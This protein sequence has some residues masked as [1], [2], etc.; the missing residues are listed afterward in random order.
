MSKRSRSRGRAAADRGDE[1]DRPKIDAGWC[2][3]ISE[4]SGLRQIGEGT[5]GTVYRALDKSMDRVVALKKV[6]LHN[7][8]QDGFPLTSLREIRLL[9]RISHPNCV[10][11]LDVAVGSEREAVYLVFEYCEHDLARLIDSRGTRLSVFSEAQ[12]KNLALQLLSA[13]AH[14]HLHWIVHRDLKMSNLLYNS[15]GHLKLADFGL[16]RE[17]YRPTRDM[18]LKV[19][20]LWYRAPELL[21]GGNRY[22]QSV[23]L[24]AAGCIIGELLCGR[25]LMPGQDEADQIQR[26]F[27]LLGAPHETIWPSL[28]TYSGAL[29]IDFE[30][31]HRRHPFNMLPQVFPLL[32]REGLELLDGLLTYDPS[33]RLNAT[34]ALTHPYFQIKPQPTD[35]DLMP[36][37]ASTHVAESA[38]R[39]SGAQLRGNPYVGF[40]N[41]APNNERDSA[42]RIVRSSGALSAAYT[43]RARYNH[44]KPRRY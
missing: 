8:K 33:R 22:D 5:Y 31:E 6:I 28:N 2:R 23:D 37:F 36:T 10:R 7:E 19:V 15:R 39:L 25:P 21:L 11:L 30:A 26:V 35:P 43:Y 24:W 1:L 12:V 16:A 34:Q 17:F 42:A 44:K 40:D 20:T 29:S 27:S 38:H 3:E 4:F 14:L 13:V 18:T 32:K 9:R 41:A